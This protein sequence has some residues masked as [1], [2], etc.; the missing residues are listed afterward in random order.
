M[1]KKTITYTDY[2]GL[3][4]TEDFRFNLSE[5]EIVE[6]E[7]TAEGGLVASMKQMSSKKDAPAL[8]KTFKNIF[9]KSYG[10]I[11]PDGR[12]FMKS[13]EISDAFSQTKAYDI[14]FLELVHDAEKMSK[15]I[16]G[17][18]GSEDA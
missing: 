2:N 12:R 3:E 1:I 5:S 6:M 4:R 17:I 11:S 7:M 18:I 9:L 14:I 16:D 13:Q 15:F 8:M 10:E